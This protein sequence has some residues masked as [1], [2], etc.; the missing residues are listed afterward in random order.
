MT[1]VRT[2]QTRAGWLR[3]RTEFVGASESASI[4]GVG[5]DS[6]LAVYERK[7]NPTDEEPTDAQWIGL[8]LE[9]A[10]AS[11]FNE[12]TGKTARLNSYGDGYQVY[13]HSEHPWLRAT[14]DAEI[15]EEEAVLELKNVGAYNA[16]EWS[17]D[18]VPLR[19]QVQL[20]HQMLVR[21]WDH[22]YLGAL[23][24]GNTPLVRHV[25]ADPD[26]QRA[27]LDRL[28][29]FWG[30][31]ERRDPPDADHTE[32]CTK[33]L[34]RLHPNDNGQAAWVDLDGAEVE[35]LL[36]AKSDR[37]EADARIRALENRIR[38]QIGDASYGVAEDGSVWSWL[39][40][41]RKEFTVAAST[42]RTLRT[43][44]TLPSSVALPYGNP[45]IRPITPHLET[46]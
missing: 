44:K 24:G 12:V 17:D 34:R 19:F 16:S 32:S 23:V 41:D 14:L 7:I 27:L 42:N 37:K 28:R 4:L 39:T 8:H 35:A 21:G 9:S 10:I 38:Q 15:V 18:Q 45:R 25:E 33:L 11:I 40:S 26:F 22:G 46:T 29:D 1:K 43:R 13:E 36:A 2:Y 30:R 31:V 3:E 20:Q 5:Y 6:E